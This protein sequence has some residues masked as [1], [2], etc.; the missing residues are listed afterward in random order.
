M[1]KLIKI[2]RLGWAIVNDSTTPLLDGSSWNWVLPRPKP[3]N[4]GILYY[5]KSILYKIVRNFATSFHF[6]NSS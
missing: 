3:Y 5:Y 4:T 2:F 1:I 6:S